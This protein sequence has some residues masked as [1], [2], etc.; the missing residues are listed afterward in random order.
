MVASDICVLNLEEEDLPKSSLSITLVGTASDNSET[1]DDKVI[2]KLNAKEYIDSQNNKSLSFDLLYII[3]RKK[4]NYC[5]L[6]ARF[7]VDHHYISLDLYLL[8]MIY[9]LSDLHKLILSK[10]LA[11]HLIKLQPT[12][13]KREKKRNQPCNLP[14]QL[15]R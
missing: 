14:H 1:N 7:H 5:Q 15:L 8:L 10:T 6:Q 3:F 12:L 4:V 13:G 11:H 2:L 9:Y